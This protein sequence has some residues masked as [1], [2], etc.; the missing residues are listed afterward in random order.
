MTNRKMRLNRNCDYGI[1]WFLV[2]AI[3]VFSLNWSQAQEAKSSSKMGLLPTSSDRYKTEYSKQLAMCRGSNRTYRLEQKEIE[4]TSI[5]TNF[6]KT[7]IRIHCLKLD[8]D[9][10]VKNPLTFKAIRIGRTRPVA[11]L[12]ETELES[13]LINA[14]K[15]WSARDSIGVGEKLKF[16]TT[17]GVSISLSEK[18]FGYTESQGFGIGYFKAQ[19]DFDEFVR[20]LEKAQQTLD[21][22]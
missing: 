16:V 8:R 4:S 13:F 12:D 1:S 3:C 19:S 20:I 10:F 17:T 22:M 7:E 5:N 15:I 14:K 21:D 6:G 2:L 9:A 18:G 11:Y